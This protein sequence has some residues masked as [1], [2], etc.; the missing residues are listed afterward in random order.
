M[1]NEKILEKLKQNL[2][3]IIGLIIIVGF[4]GFAFFSKDDLIPAVT[5][6]PRSEAERGGQ[7]ERAKENIAVPEAGSNA[8][9]PVKKIDQA[10]NI[11]ATGQGNE[12]LE[13]IVYSDFE[14]PFCAQFALTLE[15]ARKEFGDQITFAFR[16]FPLLSSHV[17]AL[18]AALSAECAG[19]QGKFW[20]MHDKLFADNREGRMSEARFKEDAKELGLDMTKFSQCLETEKY[21]DKILTQMLEAKNFNVNGTPTT[22]INGEIVVGAYPFED[23][24]APDGTKTE[25]LKS[26]ITRHLNK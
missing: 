4:V 25:G 12:R 11:L 10:D 22:F 5:D 2:F 26:I 19:E 8:I 3:F 13:F 9:Q 23:F 24:I 1:N 17:Y 14:C 21:K 15:Q 16:H 20:E 6:E 7:E 18:P